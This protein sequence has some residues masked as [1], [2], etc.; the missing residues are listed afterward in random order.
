M[1]KSMSQKSFGNERPQLR[2]PF[3]LNTVCH[4]VANLFII[5]KF[6]SSQT[7]PKGESSNT[8]LCKGATTCGGSA[9]FGCCSVSRCL[10]EKGNRVSID[11][12]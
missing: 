2:K 7:W 12:D 3:K 10:A 5:R 4:L 11:F 6:S 9:C 8:E 1:S